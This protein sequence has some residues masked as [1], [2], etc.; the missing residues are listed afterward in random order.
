MRLL[1]V[2]HRLP[3]PPHRGDSLMIHGFLE[4]MRR[5]CMGGKSDLLRPGA[6]TFSYVGTF[7]PR[8]EIWYFQTILPVRGCMA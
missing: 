5:L 2:S 6:I 3:F 4:A 8:S 7:M 1:V